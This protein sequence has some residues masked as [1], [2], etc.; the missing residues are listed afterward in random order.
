MARF[1]TGA[2][3]MAGPMAGAAG[4]P[5]YQFLGWNILGR[6]GVVHAWW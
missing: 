4:M 2:R 5:F 3:F 6:A 1:I